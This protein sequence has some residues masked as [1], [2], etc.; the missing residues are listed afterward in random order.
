M[1]CLTHSAA[2]QTHLTIINANEI[3]FSFLLMQQTFETVWFGVFPTI[4]PNEKR[5]SKLCRAL[6]YGTGSSTP[7]QWVWH[8]SNDKN[9]Y[10]W[11]L[12]QNN[13]GR[14]DNGDFKGRNQRK[15]A[16]IT[17]TIP[18]GALGDAGAI[19][20]VH[21]PKPLPWR[22]RFQVK[23]WHFRLS[24]RAEVSAINSWQNGLPFAFYT[25]AE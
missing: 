24:E 23:K 18:F 14:V 2:H 8:G 21:A 10:I 17:R 5:M 20:A 13:R 4:T 11:Q 7:N 15:R 6:G 16:L 3:F 9:L 19:W 25:L 12:G 1:A 22:S